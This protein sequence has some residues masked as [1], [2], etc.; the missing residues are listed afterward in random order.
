VPR[1]GIE[2]S[3][4]AH[5][6]RMGGDVAPE[7][8]YLADQIRITDSM[9]AQGRITE[10]EQLIMRGRPVLARIRSALEVVVDDGVRDEKDTIVQSLRKKH[11]SVPSRKAELSTALAAYA[12]CCTLFQAELANLAGFDVALVEEATQ[13]ADALSASGNG[14]KVDTKSTVARRNRLV[15]MA[16][17]R[18]GKVRRIARFTFSDNPEIVSAFFSAFRREQKRGAKGSD[19]PEP[20]DDPVDQDPAPTPKPQDD[21]T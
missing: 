10:P 14:P 4:A 19:E 17:T 20:T 6:A 8:V 16:R 15:N 18:I 7:L 12:D 11:E 5:A 9:I 2:A 13:I 3:L 1:D 21:P